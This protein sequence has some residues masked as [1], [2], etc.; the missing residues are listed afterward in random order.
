LARRRRAIQLAEEDA[1]KPATHLSPSHLSL[2]MTARVEFLVR[3]A[4][5][6]GEENRKAMLV[7]DDRP[8]VRER[9]YS[10]YLARKG[11]REG[12]IEDLPTGT[13]PAQSVL[14]DVATRLSSVRLVRRGLPIWFPPEKGVWE[15][16]WAVV[17]AEDF[18][19]LEPLRSLVDNDAF[20]A[21][22]FY[23]L[24]WEARFLAKENVNLKPAQALVQLI[25]R[26]LMAEK[27]NE[28]DVARLRT[29]GV[30]QLVQ[31]DSQRFDLLCMLV[32]LAEQGGFLKR[33]VLGFDGLE[34]MLEE[35]ALLRGVN[36]FI[37]SIER[38]IKVGGSPIGVLIG[39]DATPANMDR[40]R[41]NHPRLAAHVQKGLAWTEE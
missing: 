20:P 30:S 33:V 29:L 4:A 39:F 3:W 38:W 36:R 23:K 8:A 2:V 5:S 17:A 27:L 24:L 40:L 11:A 18:V 21:H 12:V 1:P 31:T 25:T 34:T 9:F 37:E 41:A 19:T 28:E 35:P 26:W 10:K 13:R 15:M 16:L 14:V 32:T 6:F 22:Y 7:L